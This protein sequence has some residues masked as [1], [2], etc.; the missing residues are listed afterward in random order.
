MIKVIAQA[1][2][3]EGSFEKVLALYEELV[4]KTRKEEGCISYELFSE[5]NNE[6]NIAL[7]E[8]WTSLEA[9]DKHTKTDHFIT[10]V[11]KLKEY[12]QEEPV[13]LYKKII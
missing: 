3:K 9:L 12:E 10:I 1:K 7:I 13:L 4:T 11:G 2:L 6:N 8:E 5:L